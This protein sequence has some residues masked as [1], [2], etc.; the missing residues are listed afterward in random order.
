MLMPE[1]GLH[2]RYAKRH[3]ISIFL[4]YNAF[5]TTQSY[6]KKLYLLASKASI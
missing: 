2:F 6:P 3:C 1:F 5:F 4:K